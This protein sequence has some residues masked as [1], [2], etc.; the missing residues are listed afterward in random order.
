MAVYVGYEACNKTALD[1]MSSGYWL[2][3]LPRDR[4]VIVWWVGGGGTMDMG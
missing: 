4:L 2:V 3:I 1:M